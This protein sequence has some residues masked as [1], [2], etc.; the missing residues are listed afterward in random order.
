LVK[1]RLVVAELDTGAEVGGDTWSSPMRQWHGQLSAWGGVTR[2]SS[3]RLL[4]GA[5][6]VEA[7]RL[8]GGGH[9]EQASQWRWPQRADAVVQESSTV[10][11]GVGK[12]GGAAEAEVEY[13]RGVTRWRR[14]AVERF[15]FERGLDGSEQ[16][17]R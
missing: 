14:S 12:V 5:S 15:F 4:A 11:R 3:P 9:G 17:S 10:E 16:T 7:R 8:G 2:S 1:W 13:G 6:V